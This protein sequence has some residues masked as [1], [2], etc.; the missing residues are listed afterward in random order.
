MTSTISRF[1]TLLV[2]LIS[3]TSAT[4]EEKEDQSIEVIIGYAKNTSNEDI[5]ALEKKLQITP[6]KKFKRIYA[7]CYKLPLSVDVNDFITKVQQEKIVKYAERNGKV[8]NK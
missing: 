3:I 7:I 1:L 2:I 8:A 4:A 5:E 6:T